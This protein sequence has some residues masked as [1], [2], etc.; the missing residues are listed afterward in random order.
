[1]F[2]EKEILGWKLLK[3]KLDSTP[4]L[5]LVISIDSFDPLVVETCVHQTI[6]ETT[7]EILLL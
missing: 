4:N 7:E 6:G 3:E 5:F 2:Q 1:M